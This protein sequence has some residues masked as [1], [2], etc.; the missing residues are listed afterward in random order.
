ME[1]KQNEKD[2]KSRNLLFLLIAILAAMNI[3]IGYN[4]WNKNKAKEV[5]IAQ[6]TVDKSSLE[7]E[8][9]A[10]IAKFEQLT[11]E[12]E[13]LK[14]KLQEQDNALNEKI[15]QIKLLLKKGNLTESEFRK[16]KNEISELKLQ[17]ENY[18]LKIS[19]LTQQVETLT[20]EK[21]GLNEELGSE[22]QKTADQLK[23]IESKDRTI[24][25]AKR[26]HAGAIIVTGVRERKLFGKK[27]VETD[28][29]SRTEEIKVKFVLDK[30][31]I[32]DSG[33]KDIFVKIIGPDGAPIATKVQTTKVDG[34]ETLYTEKKTI[35]YQNAKIE[36][37]VYC[38]K[39][40][41][42]PKGVYT[43]DIFAEGYRVGTT[44]MTLK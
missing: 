40:G 36:G 39:Q 38:K 31:E 3:G 24:S 23:V 30:N 43:I 29:A 1:I 19:E 2:K 14:G 7:K 35:D 21:E 12:N 13:G 28:K 27:E 32:S 41:D 20:V 44:K 42:Y 11:A 22:R 6:L 18:K 4:L 34:T 9:Q 25:K 16:A 10:E 26:L 5:Q 8:L 17:I 33:E 15:S 37:V